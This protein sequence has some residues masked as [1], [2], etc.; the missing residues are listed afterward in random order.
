MF[1]R[2]TADGYFAS[3]EGA[4]DWQVPDAEMDANIATGL[5]TGER[6]AVL[7]GRKTYEM[8]AGFW[9]NVLAQGDKAENPHAP[10]ERSPVMQRMAQWLDA[11]EKVVFSTTLQEATWRNTR[12]AR[13]IDPKEIE[14]MKRRPGEGIMIF[15]SGSIVSQLT[16]HGLI[17]EYWFVVTPVLLGQG[18]SLFRD[19]PVRTSLVLC[20]ATAHK[21]GNVTLRYEPKR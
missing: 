12:I 10:G 13:T 4:L 9:P 17:D 16:A 14:E 15:G 5:S 6:G 8:F 19:I 2:V 18:R 20:E 3:A 11:A 1:N 7:F 21:S